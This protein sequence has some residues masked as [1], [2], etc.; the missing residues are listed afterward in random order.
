MHVPQHEVNPDALLKTIFT[1]TSR[2][3]DE[4]SLDKLL[5]LMADMGREMILAD[6]CTLWLLDKEKGELRTQ[7][8]HEVGEIRTPMH[9]G[10]VGDTIRTGQPLIIND[11]YQDRRFNPEIDLQTGYRTHALLVIPIRNNQGEVIGA[12]QAI[13][14]RTPDG[15]FHQRDLDY[16]SLAAYYAGKSLE[17]AMLANEIAETQREVIYMMGEV[18]ESRSRETG[19]HVKRVAKYSK[20]LAVGYGLSESESDLI[21]MASPMHDIGKVA[22]PDSIL[23]KPG[24]LTREEYE[25]MKTHTTVGYNILSK[26]RREILSSAAIIAGQH[27]ERWDGKGYPHGIGGENIHLYGRITAVADVFDALSSHRCYKRAWDLDRVLDLFRTERGSHFD[28]TLVDVLFDTLAEIVQVRDQYVDVFDE[29]EDADF[30][31]WTFTI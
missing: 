27:H 23:K 1:Y 4:R 21:Q 26:S 14:K 7:V 10:V 2:I 31:S 29:L 16:L 24:K 22:I 28:P 17:A 15:L 11:A 20:I 6:R 18:G 30:S 13:N 5:S 9:A 3:A 25:L 8:A 12:F 19:Y